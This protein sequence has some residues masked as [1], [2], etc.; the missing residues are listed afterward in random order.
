MMLEYVILSR[1]MVLHTVLNHRLD[2]QE[3]TVAMTAQ[4]ALTLSGQKRCPRQVKRELILS[5]AA[6][7]FNWQGS[8]ATTL[9]EV[10]SSINL[11]K[12]CLYYYVENKQDLVYQCYVASCEMSL[13]RARQASLRKGS[14]LDKLGFMISSHLRH[15]AA[16]LRNEAP[17]FAMLAEISSLNSARR[18]DIG[19]RLDA[20]FGACQAMVELGISDGSISKRDSSVVT[21]VI[22][23]II[24]WF[25]AWLNKNHATNIDYVVD[26]VLDIV[27]N[28]LMSGFYQLT[29]SARAVLNETFNGDALCQQKSLTKRESFIRMGS[30]F[31]NQKGYRGTSLDEIAEALAVT[32]GSFY[33]HIKNKEEL[34]YQCFS[35]TLEIEAKFLADI[36]C[37]DH[38]GAMKLKQ[39]LFQLAAIQL[40]PEGPLIRYRLLPSLDQKHRRQILK[41]SQKNASTLGDFIRLGLQDGTLRLIDAAIVQHLLRGAV[42]AVPDLLDDVSLMN[43]QSLMNDYLNIFING[44]SFKV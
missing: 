16:S 27:C 9:S 29:D 15:F 1:S 6:A 24:Q 28:G 33:Y 3:K 40:S 13:D 38:C 18:E 20:I 7:L 11:T 26:T 36:D 10:A 39:A 22:F 35:R 37:S 23:S 21:S 30:I 5:K 2:F 44:L 25:P 8:R 14:G 42:E 32:K 43:R 34:L 12:T 19:Q 17:H 31:F 4:N 41:G